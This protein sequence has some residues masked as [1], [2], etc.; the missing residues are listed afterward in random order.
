MVVM[1]MELAMVSGSDDIS[2]GSGGSSVGGNESHIAGCCD[3]DGE[4]TAA[5][6]VVIVVSEYCAAYSMDTVAF[7][8]EWQMYKS[9][10]D[11]F[12]TGPSIS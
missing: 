6:V 8:Q 12:R 10:I 5:V 4:V 9:T 7:Q 11:E 2:N 3:G 1:A